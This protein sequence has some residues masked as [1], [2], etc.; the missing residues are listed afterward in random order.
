MRL[1]GLDDVEQESMQGMAS[2]P[3]RRQVTCVFD[4]EVLYFHRL[5]DV[6]S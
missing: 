4:L 6:S 5:H 3:S 2:V 1:E